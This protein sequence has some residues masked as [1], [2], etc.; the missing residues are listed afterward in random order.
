MDL[1][2]L[3]GKVGARVH[4]DWCLAVSMDSTENASTEAVLLELVGNG[5]VLAQEL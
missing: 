5:Y 1:V 3:H 4:T 2:E